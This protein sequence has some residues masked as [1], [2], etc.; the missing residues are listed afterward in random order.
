MGI[1]FP[2]RGEPRG[3][4]G[5]GEY[6]EA[7]TCP[8]YLTPYTIALLERAAATCAT[9]RVR[10]DLL[11]AARSLTERNAS[12]SNLPSTDQLG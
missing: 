5:C 9:E 3:C 11:T 2:D 6:A 4:T 8:L 10:I 7:C 1:I 12:L